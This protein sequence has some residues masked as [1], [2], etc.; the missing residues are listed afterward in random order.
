MNYSAAI[1]LSGHEVVFALND[2][3]G[4]V[5]ISERCLM[6]GKNSANLLS[7]LENLLAVHNLELGSIMSWT[8]GSGPGNFTGMRLIAAMVAGV[9]CFNPSSHT[10]CV[11]TAVAMAM[12]V[13]SVAGDTIIAFFDGRNNELIVFGMINRGGII[14]PDGDGVLIDIDKIEDLMS[15]HRDSIKIA[16]Q[17]D[18]QAINKI[19]PL[20]IV[21]EIAFIDAILP[22]NLIM[23]KCSEYDN[24]LT[25]LIYIRPAVAK[26]PAE[27]AL[28]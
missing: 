13:N 23:S 26:S 11:P 16:F 7:W 20:N 2:S 22:E 17:N 6:N 28:K 12:Q 15:S 10:R 25:N 21:N 24:D 18:Y 8:V 14:Y 19:L 3:L 1:D 4:K 9:T 5:I 27:S